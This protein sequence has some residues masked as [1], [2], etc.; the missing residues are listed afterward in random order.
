MID[1]TSHNISGLPFLHWPNDRINNKKSG[2]F[3]NMLFKKM[4]IYFQREREREREE[5]EREQP[6]GRE[7]G[8]ERI[9]SRL[10][11]DSTEP[12]VGLDLTNLEIKT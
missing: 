10:H 12:N 11:T 8:G 7:T 1:I 4:F 3:F 6:K 2:I 5:E 9:P